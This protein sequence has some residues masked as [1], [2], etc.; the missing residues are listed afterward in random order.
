LSLRRT[1][2]SS[3]FSAPSVLPAASTGPLRV[4]SDEK[5]SAGVE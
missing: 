1:L 5:E 2:R 3:S 4:L